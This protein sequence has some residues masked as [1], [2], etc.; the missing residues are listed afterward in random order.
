MLLE[1][2][3]VPFSMAVSHQ[4]MAQGILEIQGLL[5][6]QGRRLTVEYQ[7]VALNAQSS[8]WEKTPVQTLVI[9]LEDLQDLEAKKQLWSRT[10]LLK[11]RRLSA[12][13]T[14]PGLR[15]EGLVLKIA[16]GDW[17]AATLLVSK[18]RLELSELR[19]EG[20]DE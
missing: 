19:L 1:S 3:S 13:E 10:I 18:A 4:E 5:S 17:R 9:A 15:P 14:M 11:P 2:P 7:T 16:R 20:L 6:Y 12:L 8:R